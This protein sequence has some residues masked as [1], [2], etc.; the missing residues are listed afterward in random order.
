MIRPFR[1]HGFTRRS[2]YTSAS[3][4]RRGS[5]YKSA[6]GSTIGC[7]VGA[8][9]TRP[10]PYHLRRYV[11][12][13]RNVPAGHFSI[14]VEM[15]Q[16][17]IAPM[18]EEGY[19]LPEKLLPDIS[20]G[21]MF[22]AFLRDEFGVDTDKLPTYDHY[23]EDG[24]VVPA[25]AYPEE[26]LPH[27][28]R[29]LREVWIPQR[30]TEY[31]RQR[32]REPWRTCL[33]CCRNHPNPSMSPAHSSRSPPCR[34]RGCRI[35]SK[36]AVGAIQ[37]LASLAHTRVPARPDQVHPGDHMLCTRPQAG[38]GPRQRFRAS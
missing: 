21:R 9:P 1:G 8:P 2:P 19:T 23:Y 18:E 34:H 12:N 6:N 28:R 20:Q 11:R 16:A 35:A 4:W 33:N 37:A 29:H 13:R 32:D 17:I 25:K 30:A 3:G 22:C 7:Q 24:R 38:D 27:F 31:F 36:P 26:L 5:P 14:L 10:M 15:M